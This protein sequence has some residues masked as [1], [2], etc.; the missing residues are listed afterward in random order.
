MYRQM[1]T[2]TL[3]TLCCYFSINVWLSVGFSAL[4]WPVHRACCKLT[5]RATISYTLV[6]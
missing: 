6:S 3:D 2:A 4:A 5:P 1:N